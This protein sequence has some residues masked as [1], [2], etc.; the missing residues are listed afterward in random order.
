MKG[1]MLVL[2]STI[3]I[4]LIFILLFGH[5]TYTSACSCAVSP[6]VSGEFQMQT[7]VFSGKVVSIA[8]PNTVMKSTAD[9]IQVNFE[10][11]EVWKGDVGRKISITTARDSASCGFDFVE[12]QQYLVY[13]GGEP[14][15]PQVLLCGRTIELSAA[16]EDLHILGK[17]MAPSENGSAVSDTIESSPLHHILTI[18]LNSILGLGILGLA[19]YVALKVRK[20]H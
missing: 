2:K 14:N 7:A 3:I 13:A 11:F 6:S 1:T 20:Y 4:A 18:V 15:H 12:G 5:S 8:L 17:G 19:L 16:E 9:P 10:V